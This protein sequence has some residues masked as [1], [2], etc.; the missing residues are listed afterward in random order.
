MARAILSIGQT[1]QTALAPEK[2][3][4]EVMQYALLRWQTLPSIISHSHIPLLHIFQQ[5]VELQE[6]ATVASA[7]QAVAVGKSTSDVSTIIETWHHRMPN[8]WD[9]MIIWHDILGWR[10]PI[11]EKVA[12]QQEKLKKEDA[13]ASASPSESSKENETVFVL[14][15]LIHIARLHRLKGVCT[16][17]LTALLR[18]SN[19]PPADVFARTREQV[20]GSDRDRENYSMTY[21]RPLPHPSRLIALLFYYAVSYSL[22]SLFF[23]P[24]F[25]FF[26]IIPL[27]LSLSFFLSLSFSPSLS[28]SHTHTF[29]S[30]F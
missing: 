5:I 28:L 30:L 13:S 11:L 19:V 27:Y 1:E 16:R 26:S 24:F 29:F 10:M 18:I 9:E 23:S 17:A 3:C 22:Y 4:G 15:Q 2:I 20:D 7:L 14:T 8:V 25:C 6:S 21:L 12:A